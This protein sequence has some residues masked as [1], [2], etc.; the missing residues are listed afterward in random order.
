V[1]ILAAV[2]RSDRAPDGQSQSEAA[3]HLSG[4]DLRTAKILVG[5]GM[6]HPAALRHGDGC[7]HLSPRDILARRRPRALERRLRA[8]LA[9]ADR[10][11][12]WQQPVPAAALLSVSSFHQ[13]LARRF[14]I[15]VLGLTAR[16]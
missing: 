2:L 12:L 13:A 7:R 1:A 3:P 4:S 5:S 15:A 9:P 6:H 11:P 8:A 10:R 16:A 14:S